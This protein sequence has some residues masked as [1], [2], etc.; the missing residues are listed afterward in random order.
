MAVPKS[1]GKIVETRRII[2]TFT[3]PRMHI[4]MT[5]QVSWL[6]NSIKDS[7]LKWFYGTKLLL[8]IK[9]LQS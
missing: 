2:N 4:Y 8:S 5:T 6:G 9:L 3:V 7:D 1:N